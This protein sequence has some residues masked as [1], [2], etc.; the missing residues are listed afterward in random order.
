[1]PTRK[2]KSARKITRE[3]EQTRARI[4]QAAFEEFSTKGFAGAR[5]SQ[6][7]RLAGS[8]KRMLYHYFGNKKD[9]FRAVLQQKIAERQAVASKA[10]GN[11]A[12]D[13]P[14]WF[15]TN[16]QYAGWIR[17]LGWES[18][19]TENKKLLDEEERQELMNRTVERIQQQ[20]AAGQLVDHWDPRHVLLAM[21]S[22]T[23]FPQAHSQM[24]RLITG[25]SV[26]DPQ[27]QTGYAAFLSQFSAAFVPP[28]SRVS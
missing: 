20:Q 5:V 9:L 22:L 15:E 27:F 28:A 8:N 14:R 25:Q 23:T 16:C 12:I 17:L 13:L 21:M 18:L 24:A 4:L 11:P 3:P 19:Q 7:S 6:I 10:T 26:Q 1:M 2:K